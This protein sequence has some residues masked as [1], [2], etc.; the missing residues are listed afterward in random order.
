M[1][2]STAL[3]FALLT[4]LGLAGCRPRE[5]RD[6]DGRD[7]R[8]DRRP[9]PRGRRPPPP[10][11]AE[12]ATDWEVGEHVDVEWKGSFWHGKIMAVLPGNRYRIHYVGWADSFDE[13]VSGDRIRPLSVETRDGTEVRE[14]APPPPPPPRFRNGDPVDVF[15]EGS[16]WH[17]RV[18]GPGAQPGA[19][20]VHYIGWD[21]RYDESVMPS[22]IR[23]R[24]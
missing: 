22:R 23:R 3:A 2:R 16:W 18:V 5:P 1:R 8:D 11:S 13:A 7:E 9:P 15:W 12:A 19:Y 21:E 14:A 17:A 6:P 20:R 10:P 4:L 24:H